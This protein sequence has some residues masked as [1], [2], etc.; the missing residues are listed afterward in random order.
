MPI[1]VR[2]EGLH[3]WIT[4]TLQSVD[5]LLPISFVRRVEDEKD[6]LAGTSTD[7]LSRLPRELQMICCIFVTEHFAVKTIVIFKLAK[8]LEPK[9]ITIKIQHGFE[10]MCRTRYSDVGL[11]KARV[12]FVHCVVISIGGWQLT[13][14]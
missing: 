12:I 10:I 6:V 7:N 4:V 8:K 14:F 2:I 9:P 13:L 1:P 3:S 11:S 5:H